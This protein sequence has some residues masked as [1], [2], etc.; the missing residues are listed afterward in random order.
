[1]L[2]LAL[3]TLAVRLAPS[4]GRT[5]G[6]LGVVA[7]AAALVVGVDLF[8]GARLQ[9][10][11]VAGYSAL[12]GYRYAG[13][14]TVGLGVFL[15][16]VLL[17]AGLLA[18][19]VPRSW[20]PA[21]V[22]VVG[23]AGVLLVG[24]PYLG[25][26]PVGAVALTAGVSIATAIC[27]GGWL[28]LGRLAGAT[29]AGLLVTAGF[30]V[31]DLRRP[32]GERGSLGRMLQDLAD[33]TG[34]SAVHRAGAAN[35]EALLGSPL[36]VLALVGAVLVWFA[37]LRDW[38]G[39]KRAFGL[40]PALRA[41]LIGIA[42]AAVIGGVLGGSALDLAGAAAAVT[43]PLAALAS[44]RVLDHAAD[45][46]QPRAAPPP[47]DDATAGVEIVP[48]T[49]APAAAG[50]PAGAAAPASPPRAAPA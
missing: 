26:D 32:E 14:G 49:P 8:T 3:G 2:V 45:R 37:L 27:T 28:S 22:A 40:Y 30:A 6:P 44:L 4:F 31:I 29:V 10:N 41:G 43:V 9:L 7:P 36:T 35:V 15:S 13:V 33:G 48:V 39:L 20:R 11:G 16:G 12:E 17:S 46:T 5:L 18:Q 38:G 21:V 42:V 23:G 1:M 24:S 19:R 50:E 47:D 34:G 25:A